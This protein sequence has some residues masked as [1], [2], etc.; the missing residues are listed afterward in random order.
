MTN[1]AKIIIY[2][3]FVLSGFRAVAS[4]PCST[5]PPFSS[6][7][8]NPTDCGLNDGT[9]TILA[10]NNTLQYSIDSGATWQTDSIFTGL[11]EKTYY[12]GIRSAAD[13]TCADTSGILSLIEPTPPV[14]GS[15]SSTD[16]TDCGVTDGTI[17][18]TA[19][20]SGSLAYSIDGGASFQ[21]S[22]VFSNLSGSTYSILVQNIDGTCII[23]GNSVFLTNKTPPVINNVNTTNPS[24]CNVNDGTI[25][26]SVTATSVEF[27]IDGGFNWQGSSSFTGL[28]ADTYNV[29]VRNTDGTCEVFS[30]NNPITLTSPIPPIINNIVGTS[31]TDC[32]VTDGKIAITA[33]SGSGTYQ[34]SIDGGTNWSVSSIFSGLA[35][36][37][38][39]VH[40]RNADGTCEVSGS[41]I[42]L[43]DKVA[44][45]INNVNSTNPTDCGTSDGTLTIQASSSAGN[46]LEYSID[47]GG[48]WFTFGSFIN[49]S[50]ATYSIQ[51]RNA[52]GTC[53]TSSPDI[54]LTNPVQ[55]VISSINTTNPS[56]C[57]VNDGTI[58][59]TA[60]FSGS[61]EYSMDGGINWQPSSSFTGLS[62]GI[63]NI[64]IRNADGTCEV[65][66][67][68]NPIT[69]TAPTAPTIN[70]IIDTNPT[71]CGVIDGTITITASNGSGNYEYSINSGS[72]WQVGNTFSALAGG[73]Y[74][75]QVRNADG[76]CEV[77][78]S[79]ITLTDKVAPT[80][81]N[82]T[83]ANPTDCG[84]SDGTITIQAN[85]SAGNALE[86]SIDGGA[87]WQTSNNF[88]GLSG[89]GSPYQIR[90]RNADGTCQISNNDV[91][92][93]NP[94]QPVITNVN[95]TSPSTCSSNSATITINATGIALEYS[96]D[97]GINWQGSNTFNNLP[98]GIY[99][100]AV[101]NNDGN[102]ETLD[103]NNPLTI[104]SAAAPNITNE[105]STEP[106]DCGSNDGT[107][108]INAAGGSTGNYHY[109][110]DGAI[111]WQIG[112]TF[113]NLAGGSYSIRVRN[114]DQTCEITGSTI[115]LTDKV[116]PTITNINSSNSTD[117]I[118]SDGSINI[119]ANSSAGNSL[120]YSIDAGTNWQ[121]SNLFI[122]LGCGTYPIR[123]RNNDGS[124]LITSSDVI[125][126][127]TITTIDTPNITT[128]TTDSI[129]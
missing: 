123:V 16:P 103:F 102:C 56:N 87:T 118:S 19:S 23:S 112:N 25:T 83:S 86:Y 46:A 69:L 60:T 126:N 22:N 37:S 70:S 72:N 116:A 62:S 74:G 31:S 124:C 84:T 113:S 28:S 44:P 1:Y 106:T 32:G 29:V 52:D 20:G 129:L 9:I 2:S 63:Y 18:I 96:I 101:R 36:G 122:N 107:I 61:A 68:N 99:N 59:I 27:S 54:T 15:V 85:S 48:T 77:S 13:P 24:N 8:T 114:D 125:L 21:P 39:A 91:I 6:T 67:V 34:Y 51:V 89:S 11:I 97:A 98:S 33:S 81:N 120:E 111:T 119:Q 53:Q 10:N 35:G 66:D 73:N 90:V 3:I 121:P 94:V 58:S 43:T 76:T 4:P 78:G 117:C 88:F 50:G 17:T 92:L 65:L 104:T 40:V 93:T 38:Y 80:I 105:T 128:A 109:S 110:I 14:I 100:V 7:S 57:S 64:A 108:V 79:T 75:I 95:S 42:T 127:A 55:P 30:F 47:G 115:T 49:L 82:V 26:V 5:L 45:T 41:I 71:D 12:L